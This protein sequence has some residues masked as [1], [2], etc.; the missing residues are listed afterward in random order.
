MP[1]RRRHECLSRR[2]R[3]TPLGSTVGPVTVCITK[4]RSRYSVSFWFQ[5]RIRM[6]SCFCEMRWDEIRMRSHLHEMRPVFHEMR[7]NR[8]RMRAFSCR[9]RLRSHEMRQNR[10]GMRA[11]SCE[12]RSKI[13]LWD[14]MRSNLCEMGASGPTPSQDRDRDGTRSWWDESS[15]SDPAA[16]LVKILQCSDEMYRHISIN[17]KIM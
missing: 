8:I 16:S 9:M 5:V 4:L 6:E 14:E 3:G 2:C 15:Y 12:M 17:H 13:F 1:K 11:F 7:Q 10:T